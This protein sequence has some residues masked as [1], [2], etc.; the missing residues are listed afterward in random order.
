M[1]NAQIC[2]FC[3]YRKTRARDAAACCAAQEV[4]ASHKP[5]AARSTAPG[6]QRPAPAPSR[7][8]RPQR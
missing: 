6:L 3:R 4:L 5:A 8:P 1:D 7:F 2:M